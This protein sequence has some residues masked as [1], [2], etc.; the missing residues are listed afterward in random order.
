MADG[1]D[2]RNNHHLPHEGDAVS[3]D[4]GSIDEAGERERVAD[5]LG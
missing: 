5:E 1:D 3:G 2:S 4:T